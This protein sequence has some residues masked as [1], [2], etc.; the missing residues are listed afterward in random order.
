MVP[1]W[2][3][4][5]CGWLSTDLTSELAHFKLV[6]HLSKAKQLAFPFT[7]LLRSP[8]DPV[9]PCDAMER[10]S[11]RVGCRSEQ[12]ETVFFS[13]SRLLKVNTNMSHQKSLRQVHAFQ[14]WSSFLLMVRW[15]GWTCCAS[16]SLELEQ[17][18]MPMRLDLTTVPAGSK[19]RLTRMELSPPSIVVVFSVSP[20]SPPFGP[21]FHAFFPP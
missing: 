4:P 9:V 15:W 3:Q 17:L 5:L 20:T 16:N 1:S 7:S 8:A 10:S 11:L 18:F 6:I 2:R 14:V 13:I 21:L 19:A 12:P